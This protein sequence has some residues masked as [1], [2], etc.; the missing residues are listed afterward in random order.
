MQAETRPKSTYEQW[1]EQEGLPVT[2]AM[3]G[4]E[5][6]TQVPRGPWARLGGYGA[7]ILL[8]GMIQA[9]NGIYV[10]EIPPGQA[11]NPEKHMYEEV[12]YIVRG[13]GLTE[14]W[15]EGGPKQTFEWGENSLFA[16][17]LN[18]WHRLINGGREPVIFMGVTNAPTIMDTFH[19]LDFIFNC[20]YRFTDRYGGQSD[21]FNPE[22]RRYR[23]GWQNVWETNFIPNVRTAAVDA[24]ELKAYGD[25]TNQWEMSGN[26]LVG[27]ISEWPAGRYTKAH[28]HGPG[29]LIVAQSSKGYVLL[30]PKELGVHPFQDGYGDQVI[31]LDWKL[32]SIYA[33]P[34]GWF[35]QH[36]DTAPEPARHLAIRYG[37]RLYRTTAGG[38]RNDDNL[39]TTQ[40]QGGR[41]IDYPDEDPEIR[42][43]FLEALKREGVECTMPDELY[44]PRGGK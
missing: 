12:I 1:I 41:T 2:E 7:F 32:G 35:H 38:A 20:D 33:P 34:D 28:W 27:H 14:I 25:R 40:R 26:T 42:R 24:R 17:P 21:Y 5:D 10:G 9:G 31:Q 8:R 15:Q 6:L 19:N 36:F 18:T 29:A 30:W 43:R 13:R 44:Q 22:G 16:P 11:L 39:F 3:G 23:S 37:S 4:I